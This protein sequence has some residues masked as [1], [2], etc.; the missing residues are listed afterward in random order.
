MPDAHVRSSDEALDSDVIPSLS[1][2]S[3][4]HGLR[5]LHLTCALD[6]FL[7]TGEEGYCR[8]RHPTPCFRVTLFLVA[9]FWESYVLFQSISYQHATDSAMLFR[10]V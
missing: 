1:L 5:P 4:R 8:I 7:L 2:F 9:V 3:D 10:C 6:L